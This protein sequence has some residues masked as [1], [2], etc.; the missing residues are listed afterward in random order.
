MPE[1]CP[2]H[3]SRGR[4]S[5]RQRGGPLPASRAGLRVERGGIG[6]EK[7]ENYAPPCERAAPPSRRRR[8]RGGDGQ[9]H[10]SPTLGYV[11]TSQVVPA[12]PTCLSIRGSVRN[13]SF[14]AGASRTDSHS[15][16]TE[17]R[18]VLLGPHTA[19]SH[20]GLRWHCLPAFAAHANTS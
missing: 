15:G 7:D 3:A 17:G 13:E 4:V 1:A 8:W 20:S 14:Y 9:D 11:L 16:E 19:L 18:P 10:L 12:R 5:A 6:S 2:R